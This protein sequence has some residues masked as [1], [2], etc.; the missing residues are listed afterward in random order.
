MERRRRAG[1]RA[2]AER[3]R[4][5]PGSN[6]QERPRHGPV[7][8]RGDGPEIPVAEVHA[9]LRSGVRRRRYGGHVDEETERVL[10]R[11]TAERHK[12]NTE[13]IEKKKVEEM[14]VH[15]RS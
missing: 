10:R 9:G 3:P 8:Q 13:T 1:S 2:C 12:Q 4:L 5:V 14:V 15:S 11:A 7:L 6:L